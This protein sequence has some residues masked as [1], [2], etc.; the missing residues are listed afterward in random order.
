MAG[1]SNDI[2][3]LKKLS[4]KYNFTLIEDA[5]EAFG[6]EYKNKKL[7]SFPHTTIFSFHIAKLITTVEGGCLTTKS[8]KLD[9]KMKAIRDLGRTE[10]G[11]VHQFLGT[12]L[13]ITDLQSSI[14]IE[15]LKKIEIF[16]KK[17]KKIASLYT[18][19]ITGLK[20]QSIPK[21]ATLHSHML[22]F[23]FAPN[24][25][26]RNIYVKQLRKNGIDT[27]MPWMPIHMQPCFKELNKMKFKNSENIYKTIFSLPMHNS[28]SKKE[29]LMIIKICNDIARKY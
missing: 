24:E 13:R 11:Y 5:A 7:G 2:K 25:K 29:S 14:G 16:L 4:K 20:F 21:Y 8:S 17:R 19:Q 3:T 22:F 23:A 1:L 28:L 26:M 12:N 15:Q 9:K 18:K 6:S 10:K 27:R